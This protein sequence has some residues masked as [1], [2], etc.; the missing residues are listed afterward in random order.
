MYWKQARIAKREFGIKNKMKKKK[1][2]IR[3]S[4]CVYTKRKLRKDG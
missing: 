2:I 3:K 1:K 4:L